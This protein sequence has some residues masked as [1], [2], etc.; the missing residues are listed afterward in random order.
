MAR[1][2][3]SSWTRPD[4]PFVARGGVTDWDVRQFIVIVVVIIVNDHFFIPQGLLDCY[5]YLGNLAN[6][7]LG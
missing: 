3:S 4:S 1:L 6:F 2:S 5:L 7:V